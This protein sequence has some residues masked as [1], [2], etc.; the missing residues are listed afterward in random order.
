M[1]TC[2]HPRRATLNLDVRSLE[3]LP[4]P[5]D[6]HLLPNHTN[7][8]LPEIRCAEWDVAACKLANL[9]SNRRP[10]IK[11]TVVTP[12]GTP[13]PFLT[14]HVVES[15]PFECEE[16]LCGQGWS[17][18]MC[19]SCCLDWSTMCEACCCGG[20][21]V[22]EMEVVLDG[23]HTVYDDFEKYCLICCCSGQPI[24]GTLIG[25]RQVWLGWF[26]RVR[27]HE[28]AR[29]FVCHEQGVDL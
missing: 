8:N 26:L 29:V 19:S 20:C 10:G 6:I 22:A 17:A 25:A 12:T 13:A 28:R 2:I 11:V 23:N 9:R 14:E 27:V 15:R 7:P 4:A 24:I 18:G 3:G 5:A 16:A 1:L 21:L